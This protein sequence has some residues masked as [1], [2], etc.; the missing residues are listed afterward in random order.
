MNNE[1]IHVGN[2]EKS[3]EQEIKKEFKG[4]SLEELRYQ[5]ALTALKKDFCKSKMITNF[6]KTRKRTFGGEKGNVS[7]FVRAG[8]IA[9]KLFSGLNY[10]DYAMIGMS[11]FTSGKKIYNFFSS[12]KRK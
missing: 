11:L 12:K 6:E 5:R 1:I 4:Y 7:K 8:G 2:N 3:L 10:L 9:S